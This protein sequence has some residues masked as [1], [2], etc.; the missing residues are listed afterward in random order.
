MQFQVPQF[1]EHEAKV[2]GPLTFRQFVYLGIAA[3][4]AM[5]LYFLAP[6][7]IFLISAVALGLVA[8][9]LA[10]VKIGPKTMPEL[11]VDLVNFGLSPKTYIWKAA[12]SKQT[13]ARQQT[14]VQPEENETEKKVK[15]V[16]ESKLKELR[17]KINTKN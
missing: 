7:G 3:G 2:I 10:F 5:F 9:A 17:N 13:Q 8:L 12:R 6:F 14:Y 15:L 16:R 11:I 4:I 1:I